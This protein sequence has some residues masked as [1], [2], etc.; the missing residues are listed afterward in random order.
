MTAPAAGRLALA[1]AF[2]ALSPAVARGQLSGKMSASISQVFDGNVFATSE[3]QADVISRAGPLFEIGFRALPIDLTGQYEIQ[4]EHYVNNPQL[5]AMASHHDARLA[6]RYAPRPRFDVTIDSSY[7]E[8]QSPAELNVASGLTAGRARARRIGGTAVVH[9]QL[10]PLTAIASEYAVARDSIA[11]GVSSMTQSWRGGFE[12]RVGPRDVYRLDYRFR[13]T[14]FDGG[15]EMRSHAL[16]A[17]WNHALGVRTELD[18]AAGPRRTDQGTIKPEIA[19]IVRRQL[20]RGELSISYS[21]TELTAIG[22]S[23]TIDVHRGAVSYAYRP[24]PR[25]ALTVTPAMVR[26]ARRGDAVPVYSVDAEASVAIT[27][28]FSFTGW[29]REGRQHGT[30][31]GSTAVIPYRGVGL[32][33]RVAASPADAGR[34]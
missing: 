21:S 27:R 32:K 33:L 34:R 15:T 19:A 24:S 6:L 26:S 13:Q 23:G 7:L 1:A 8:T 22:E 5:N 14:G 10:R 3:P 11:G 9:Y 4:A 20:T 30:L 17:G 31:S 2:L 28:R 18:V 25:L 12:Q 29:L 16:V